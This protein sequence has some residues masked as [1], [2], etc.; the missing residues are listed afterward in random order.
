MSG[1]RRQESGTGSLDYDDVPAEI[2]AII[3]ARLARKLS[4]PDPSAITLD[5]FERRICA[6]R[7][8]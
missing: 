4:G 2:L 1:V 6:R 3:D 8:A 5:E 7:S